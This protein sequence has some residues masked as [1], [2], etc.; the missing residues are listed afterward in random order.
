M[1]FA[2]VTAIV[3]AFAC[4]VSAQDTGA[5]LARWIA[6]ARSGALPLY[7][8]PMG[9]PDTEQWFGN[10]FAELN[11]RNVT[12]P[13]ITP[14]LPDAGK[15]NG[16]AVVVVPGGGNYFHALGNEGI[17]VAR[18]LAERGVAAFVVKYRSAPTPRDEAAF[19]ASVKAYVTRMVASRSTMALPG[20]ANA[21][22]DVQQALRFVK[23]GASRW[24]LDPDRI[25]LVGFSA[26]SIA[27]LNTVLA[28]APDARPAFAGLIYGRMVP[29]KPPKSLPPIFVALAADDPL[30]GKQGIGMVD[31]WRAAG[32][33]A[34]LHI[35]ASGGHGF[36][37]KQQGKS[38]DGWAESFYR[39]L[40]DRGFIK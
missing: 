13:T 3:L 11:V 14:I 40:K 26:G 33:S 6:E 17:P 7:P 25:G 28:D 21:R 19:A 24:G 31:T 38:S 22:K 36:G 27:T 23:S 10:S 30:F 32:G 1:R 34:E 39:W 4:P 8:T 18:W 29:V 15:A 35:Y 16:A 5:E 20:E 2:V 9:S 37:M 12:S